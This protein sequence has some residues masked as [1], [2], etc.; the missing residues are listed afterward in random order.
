MPS[1][2]F[3]GRSPKKTPLV[4][5][6]VTPAA[7][8]TSTYPG[9]FT[10]PTTRKVSSGPLNVTSDPNGAMTFHAPTPTQDLSNLVNGFNTQPQQQQPT[11]P[12]QGQTWQQ[13]YGTYRGQHQNPTGANLAELLGLFQG[14]G[15]NASAVDHGGSPSADKL[16]I[17]GQM[18]DFGSGLDNPAGGSW[19]DNPSADMGGAGAD[20][21][22]LSSGI[23]GGSGGQGG[24]NELFVNELLSRIDKLRQPVADP[25]QPLYDLMTLQR[26]QSLNG[27]PY[28]AGEDAAL[29][30]K[31]REPLTQARDAAFQRNREQAGA[32]GYLPTSGLLTSQDNETQRGYEQALAGAS[33][34]LATQA[35]TE[36]Q[37]RAEQQLSLLS[38]LLTQHQGVRNENNAGA[39]EIVALASQLP[40][41]DF[42]TLQALLGA[43]NGDASGTINDLNG[44]LALNQRGNI[45]ADQQNADNADMW[46]QVIYNLINGVPDAFKAGAK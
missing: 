24:G 34:D 29:V 6:P 2:A 7:P 40:Q 44:L 11:N 18:Y 37:A 33:N 46:G 26:I 25:L 42:Q 20:L 27:A 35:I 3:G 28:T 14:A 30:A 31:Y 10:D 45:Y 23:G 5:A 4:A 17:N 19:W 43:S 13:I 38:G 15:I 22:S 9:T 12:Y 39:D 1:I 16:M 36:K 8:A 32:R 21:S 41:L